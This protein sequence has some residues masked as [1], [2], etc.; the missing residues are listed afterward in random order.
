MIAPGVDRVSDTAREY[1]ELSGI[2]DAQ[3]QRLAG[4]EA[5]GDR[6]DHHLAQLQAEKADLLTQAAHGQDVAERLGVVRRDIVDVQEAAADLAEVKL[7]LLETIGAT[8]K[9][10]ER[11]ASDWRYARGEELKVSALADLAA[12]KVTG[13][14]LCADL[15]RCADQLREG[16]GLQ[17]QEYLPHLNWRAAAETIHARLSNL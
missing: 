5:E 13:G 1:A 8:E 6:H 17:G 3:K 11:V 10:R 15:M 2:L 4:L 16:Y 12:L 14:Q 7:R 9:Q